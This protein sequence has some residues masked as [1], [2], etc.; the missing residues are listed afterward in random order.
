MNKQLSLEQARQSLLLLLP[1]GFQ[2]RVQYQIETD[3]VV[4]RVHSEDQRRRVDLEP[5]SV[6]DLY[7]TPV[8][9]GEAM[10]E[11]VETAVKNLSTP[12]TVE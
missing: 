8:E 4:I 9:F 1:P 7:M 3:G 2:V 10:R 11:R 6:G 12:E 5:V